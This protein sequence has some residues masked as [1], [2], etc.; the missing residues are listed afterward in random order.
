MSD[1]YLVS[2]DIEKKLVML[3]RLRSCLTALDSQPSSIV[4]Q[5]MEGIQEVTEL[6][7]KQKIS[8]SEEEY[9]NK[10]GELN[11]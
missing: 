8:L 5:L 11:E 1:Y 10:L 6:V 4:Q 2:T 9:L 3:N 7:T